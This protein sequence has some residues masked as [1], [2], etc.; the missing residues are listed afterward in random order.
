[1]CINT[2]F[3]DLWR[4]TLHE[5]RDV[6]I[7]TTKGLIELWTTEGVALTDVTNV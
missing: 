2:E 1:M 6:C 5:R 4:Y 3:S 7:I